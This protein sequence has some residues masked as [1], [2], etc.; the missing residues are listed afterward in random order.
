MKDVVVTCL[1]VLD[2]IDVVRPKKTTKR[3]S[4]VGCHCC[5]NECIMLS[6]LCNREYL[7]DQCLSIYLGFS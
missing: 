3:L 1:K 5:S 6:I 2:S 4:F 7:I